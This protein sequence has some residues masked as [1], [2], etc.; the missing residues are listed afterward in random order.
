[1]REGHVERVLREAVAGRPPP[2][3]GQVVVV[4]QP[5]GPVAGILAFAAHHIIAADVEPAWVHE[6]LE[7]WDLPAPVG[8]AFVGALTEKLGAPPDSL[9]V[10]LAGRGTGRGA[11]DAARRDPARQLA[12]PGGPVGQLPHRRPHLDQRR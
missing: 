2:A 12:S 3:D 10:V 1:M 9:D 5:P 4:P 11:Q 6:R 8:A 7:P